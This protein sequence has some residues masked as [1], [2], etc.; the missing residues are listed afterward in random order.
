MDPRDVLDALS[1]DMPLEVAFD[2][3][4]GML[5]ERTHRQRQGLL[6]RHLWRGLHL[7]T[8]ASRAEVAPL[9][10]RTHYLSH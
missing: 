4:A 1:E 6:T 3:L 5:R 2:T 9:S 8:S 10:L 7:S